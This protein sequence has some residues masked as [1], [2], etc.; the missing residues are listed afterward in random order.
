MFKSI[1]TPENSPPLLEAR[2]RCVG[3]IQPLGADFVLGERSAL[4][5]FEHL[6]I[7]WQHTLAWIDADKQTVQID[8]RPVHSYTLTNDIA[9]IEPKAR[10]Y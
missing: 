6:S 7:G 2:A 5:R 9:Y 10:V 4:G 3:G 1:S 8:Y